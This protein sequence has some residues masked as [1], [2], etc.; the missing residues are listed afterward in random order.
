MDVLLLVVSQHMRFV[1]SFHHN[2][3]RGIRVMPGSAL[4]G[5]DCIPD[6]STYTGPFGFALIGA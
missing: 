4:S 6:T 5:G 1:G 2:R 3:I